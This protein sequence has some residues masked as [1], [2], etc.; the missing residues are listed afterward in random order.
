MAKT[1]DSARHYV[2]VEFY[3]MSLD[4]TTKVFFTSLKN[5][6]KR[7]VIV[8]VLFDHVGSLQY[9]DYKRTLEFLEKHDI[10]YQLMLPIKPLKGKFQRPDLRNHRKLL[11]VDGRIG[12]HGITKYHR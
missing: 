5:A 4:S 12:L 3:I 9:P 8:R 11:V 2:H 7:G 1:I 10:A 6:R